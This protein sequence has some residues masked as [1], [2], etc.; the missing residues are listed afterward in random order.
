MRLL[1]SNFCIYVFMLL[2]SFFIFI[3]RRSLWYLWSNFC[4][5]VFMLLFS[6]SILVTGGP[7]GIR[8][9][10]PAFMFSCYYFHFLFLVTGGP[11]A[12]I[13]LTSVVKFLHLCSH[14]VNFFFYFSDRRSQKIENENNSTETLTAERGDA[15]VQVYIESNPGWPKL[16]LT[17][18]RAHELFAGTNFHAQVL[19]YL[20]KYFSRS[21]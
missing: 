20:I 8:G 12:T 3:D 19:L 10:L 15:R 13:Y 16:P 7:Y 9:Q 5:Y 18:T 1:W 4:I 21:I 17:G 14:A 2:F 11:Y 6:L